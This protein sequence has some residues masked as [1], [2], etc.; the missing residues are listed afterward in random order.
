MSKNKLD[1][2]LLNICILALIVYLVYQ[3]GNLWIGVIGRLTDLLFPIFLAFVIAYALY[4]FLNFMMNH[5]IL[6]W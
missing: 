5:K 1:Y 2:K 3:T 4:P 6:H